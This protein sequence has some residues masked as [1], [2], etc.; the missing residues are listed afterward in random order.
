MH[1]RALTRAK[2]LRA[3]LDLLHNLSQR[4]QCESPITTNVLDSSV[5]D[6]RELTST[7]STRVDMSSAQPP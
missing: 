5:V 3:L 6:G 1:T 2:G 4:A 7:A